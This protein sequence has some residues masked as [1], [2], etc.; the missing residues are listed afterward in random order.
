MKSAGIQSNR[1]AQLGSEKG[2]TGMPAPPFGFSAGARAMTSLERI[3]DET[4]RE[5][6]TP[7]L[8]TERLILRAPRRGDVK[9]IASLLDDRRI[10]ANTARIP[11]PYSASDAEQFVASA[12]RQD[13]E[14]T[15]MIFC[16]DKLI[17]GCGIDPHED[18]PEIG[19]WL[20]VA[21]WGH[22][23][24]TEAVRALVDYAFGEL[25]HETLAAGARV[26]NPAS[27]R[28]LEK[29]AFQWTGVRLTRIR[30]INSAAPVDRFR[31]DRG[32][33]ESLK[34]WGRVRRVA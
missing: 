15:F 5:R 31:L 6:S 27:R 18:A 1:R 29:C 11:H 8:E 24:A 20:G 3:C 26:T 17:G 14:A 16:G 34:S 33:W 7:V 9:A 21:Y 23:Y 19:Y 10:A 22:G 2:E 25:C 30:A 4:A 12:N 32:L 13:G 28:V